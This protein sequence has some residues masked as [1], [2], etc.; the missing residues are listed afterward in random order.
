MVA[1]GLPSEHHREASDGKLHNSPTRSGLVRAR[2]TRDR[3][4][5]AP[6]GL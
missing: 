1:F 2:Q 6:I 4:L 3:Y 5:L